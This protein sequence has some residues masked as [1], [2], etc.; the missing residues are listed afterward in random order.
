MYRRD[1]RKLY[2]KISPIRNG[3]G[4]QKAAR[5]EKPRGWIV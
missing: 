1:P 5:F 4:K 3:A 2:R